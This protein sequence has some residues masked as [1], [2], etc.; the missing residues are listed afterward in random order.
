MLTTAIMEENAY[1][2]CLFELKLLGRGH[3]IVLLTL[4]GLYCPHPW[5]QLNK[6][7]WAIAGISDYLYRV[8]EP[9]TQ[10]HVPR[11]VGLASFKLIIWRNFWRGPLCSEET[12]QCTVPKVHIRRPAWKSVHARRQTSTLFMVQM[13]DCLALSFL[14]KLCLRTRNRPPLQDSSMTGTVG[15]QS[16]GVVS[17]CLPVL[18]VGCL[19]LTSWPPDSLL[20][21]RLPNFQSMQISCISILDFGP[22]QYFRWTELVGTL[23]IKQR[24]LWDLV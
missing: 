23:N 18:S 14:H 1:R 16:V 4:R 2:N 8:Y 12:V 6:E 13:L 17:C 3:S 19:L 7:W 22:T 9:M 10:Y 11:L 5:S 21:T 24:G 15:Q 20:K